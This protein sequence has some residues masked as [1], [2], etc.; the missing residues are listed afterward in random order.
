LYY[1]EILSNVIPIHRRPRGFARPLQNPNTRL[2]AV[3]G[4][5]G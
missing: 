2:F 3:P 5:S 1:S 4:V